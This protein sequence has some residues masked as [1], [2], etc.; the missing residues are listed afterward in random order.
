MRLLLLS[1]EKAE[2]TARLK[3][4]QQAQI[5]LQ[6]R[7]SLIDD[8]QAYLDARERSLSSKFLEACRSSFANRR[9]GMRRERAQLEVELKLRERQESDLRG[10]IQGLDC[11]EADY[12][13]AL[14]RMSSNPCS[15]SGSGQARRPKL[16]DPTSLMSKSAMRVTMYYSDDMEADV[17][18][19]EKVEQHASQLDVIPEIPDSPP[20]PMLPLPGVSDLPELTISVDHA[21]VDGDGPTDCS[22]ITDLRWRQS[23]SGSAN[24]SSGFDSSLLG[25]QTPRTND[26]TD[27]Q[28]SIIVNGASV[29]RHDGI[30][31]DGHWKF[32]SN[33]DS[34]TSKVHSVRPSSNDFRKTIHFP[35]FNI[36]PLASSPDTL[37]T[38]THLL[39]TSA[40][41]IIP[42]PSSTTDIIPSEDSS[43]QSRSAFFGPIP[44]AQPIGR[45]KTFRNKFSRPTSEV[46]VE[47]EERPIPKLGIFK[48]FLG[49]PRRLRKSK[50]GNNTGGVQENNSGGTLVA[51]VA[52]DQVASQ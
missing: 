39:R 12:W 36:P 42:S 24:S 51:A 45:R 20:T 3:A 22:G 11:E 21:Y 9:A 28:S 31:D 18:D 34:T 33:R 6:H 15:T 29:V 26:A 19:E 32:P 30:V 38:D 25:P 47:A 10:D 49:T 8:R 48:N 13:R 23:S 50:S 43:T 52:D 37:D 14:E 40:Y 2:R 35:S 44:G 41:S 1:Q 16:K 46:P 17:V 27:D 7:L 5:D 4:L